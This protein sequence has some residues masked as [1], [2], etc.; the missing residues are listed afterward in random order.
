MLK[1][2]YAIIII[3]M[4]DRS[5]Y[6]MKPYKK[7]NY[8]IPEDIEVHCTAV[9]CWVSIFNK[10]LD[11][12]PLL[13]EHR[14]DPLCYPIIQNAGSDISHWF[15]KETGDPKTHTDAVSN[16]K[17]IF[18]PFGRY[19][20]VPP[21]D[22]SGQFDLSFK[23]PWWK[24]K[25]FEIGLLSAKPRQISIVNML[26]KTQ[27][28]IQVAKEETMLEILDRYLPYNDHAAS[29]TWKI[30]GRPL[31]M[32]LT[33]EDNGIEDY[34]EEFNSLEID[35]NLYIPTIHL[36]FNDDLTVR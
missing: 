15:D 9:D 36:Y 27:D 32:E 8:Y 18:C 12:S 35:D 17:T 29:Y 19:L 28:I 21:L 11:L 1:V 16:L 34:A 6:L 4:V 14:G 13:F 3:N 10:V 31:D 7:R 5:K 30:L 24:D 2:I 25:T 26:S 23:T 22:P 33:L 20:H